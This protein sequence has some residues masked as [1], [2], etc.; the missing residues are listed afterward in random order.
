MYGYHKVDLFSLDFHGETQL[1]PGWKPFA[2]DPES[3]AIIARKWV[4]LE[5]PEQ[6]VKV[7]LTEG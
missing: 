6:E 1:P 2:Y 4:R 5:R 7:T 3:R